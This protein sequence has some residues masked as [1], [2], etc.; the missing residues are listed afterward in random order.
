M[1]ECL[2]EK[3]EEKGEGKGEGLVEVLEEERV[4]CL[5]VMKEIRRA[6]VDKEY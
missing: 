5:G 1:K 3:G 6:V 2:E 4:V